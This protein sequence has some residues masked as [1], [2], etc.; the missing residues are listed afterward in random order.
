[1]P[2]KQ[3]Y[4]PCIGSM[5][6][7]HPRVMNTAAKEDAPDDIASIDWLIIDWVSRNKDAKRLVADPQKFLL[8]SFT[9]L[10]VLIK[11]ALTIPL[12]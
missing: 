3:L 7:S 6:R 11:L 10:C 1:M 4:R 8:A 12:P 2:N 9:G 5:P